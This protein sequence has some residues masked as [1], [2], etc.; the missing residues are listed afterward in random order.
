MFARTAIP[1]SILFSHRLAAPAPYTEQPPAMRN[2]KSNLGPQ[3]VRV[4]DRL[5]CGEITDK[6]AVQMLRALEVREEFLPGFTKVTPCKECST[7]SLCKRRLE[8][9]AA[10]YVSMAEAD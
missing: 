8:H 3:I 9:I 10:T 1:L 2:N 5:R 4:Q 6:E 7:G